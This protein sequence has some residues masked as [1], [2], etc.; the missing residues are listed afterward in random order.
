VDKDKVKERGKMKKQGLFHGRQWLR[1]K[2]VDEEMS[3]RAIAEICE[4]D[5]KTIYYHLK[6]CGINTERRIKVSME[7]T[8]FYFPC[9]FME[10]L[11]GF[12]RERQQPM[13]SVI[14]SV[15]TEFMLRNKYNPFSNRKFKEKT[16][17][18]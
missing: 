14:R 9:H 11:R 18:G 3:I 6:K 17:Y 16:N 13:N 4:V 10:S 2:Y 7:K 5:H 12:S 15:L 1:K 8:Y